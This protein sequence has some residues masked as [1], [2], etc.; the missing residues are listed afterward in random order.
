MDSWTP[1]GPFLLWSSLILIIVDLNSYQV[2]LSSA[3]LCILVN[4]MSQLFY[5][6]K[7]CDLSQYI[8]SS[9][10]AGQTSLRHP[11]CTSPISMPLSLNPGQHASFLLNLALQ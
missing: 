11:S 9:W 2:G 6:Y 5:W 4:G 8:P 3:K 1:L 7:I 10:A